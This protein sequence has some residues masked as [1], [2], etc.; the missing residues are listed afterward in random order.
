LYYNL[1]I[2]KQEKCKSSIEELVDDPTALEFKNKE[3]E[4]DNYIHVEPA[5]EVIDKYIYIFVLVKTYNDTHVS[6]VYFLHNDHSNLIGS[7]KFTTLG[8]YTIS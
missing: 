8:I 4:T 7:I 6:F 5:I 3:V 2:L 1:L